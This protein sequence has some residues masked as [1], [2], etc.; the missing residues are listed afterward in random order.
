[1]APTMMQD[2]RVIISRAWGN[3]EKIA[4]PLDAEPIGSIEFIQKAT[5]TV[6]LHEF[7][8]QPGR[9]FSVVLLCG[10]FSADMTAKILKIVRPRSKGIDQTGPKRLD[11][12]RSM[13][14]EGDHV[15]AT[16][17]RII[18]RQSGIERIQV[19]PR[20]ETVVGQ[21]CSAE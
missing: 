9:H 21:Y 2:L 8:N 5:N 11:H 4:A 6:R 14:L 19:L 17:Q 15:G 12:V 13:E 3:F 7:T 10:I 20:P 18:R 1:M 16:N